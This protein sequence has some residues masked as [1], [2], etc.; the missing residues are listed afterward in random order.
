M[1]NAESRTCSRCLPQ[2]RLQSRPNG[3]RSPE[4]RMMRKPHVRLCVQERLMCSA[5]GR[6]AGVRIGSPVAGRAG[7]RETDGPE[8]PRRPHPRDGCESPGRN[9]SE[10][11]VAPKVSSP[12]GRAPNRRAK[13]AG[14]AAARLTRRDPPAGWERRH[15]DKGTSSNWRSPPRPAAKAAEPGRPYNRHHR[16]V[17]RRRE[18]GGGAR[19]SVEAG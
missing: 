15:G 16:E 2:G 13:A 12:G 4:S 9:A 8:A 18:G 10:R 19:S 7:R 3:K 17:G 14:T 6:P 5:G 11:E 1:R